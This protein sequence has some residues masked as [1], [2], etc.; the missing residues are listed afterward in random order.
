M[1]F[2]HVR[3][4][5]ASTCSPFLIYDAIFAVDCPAVPLDAVT[6]PTGAGD[7]FAGGF[8]GYLCDSGD[9]SFEGMKRAMLYGTAMASFCVEKFG[10]ENLTD[11]S[12]DTIDT[13]VG[14]LDEMIRTR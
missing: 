5:K 11:V 14:V 10:T 6:D 2:T 13:R 4:A 9:Y 1:E 3:C 7:T 8:A 12:G